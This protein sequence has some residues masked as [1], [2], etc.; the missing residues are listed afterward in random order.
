MAPDDPAEKDLS[1]RF[2][3]WQRSLDRLDELLLRQKLQDRRLKLESGMQ[4]VTD[5]EPL[6]RLLRD[7]EGAFERMESGQYGL[8]QVCLEPI[9][10]DRLLSDPLAN[11]CLEHL[12][13]NQR[14]ALDEDLKL[15]WRIQSQ[16]LPER[17]IRWNGWEVCYHYEP[18]GSVPGDYCDLMRMESGELYFLLGDVSGKG[19]AAS[20]LMSHLH[21]MFHSLIAAGLPFPE[22]VGHA[23][24]LL[25]ESTT[26][27]SFATLT[28]GRA[29]SSGEVQIC[30]AGHCPLVWA[31]RTEITNLNATGIPLGIL[32]DSSY[33]MTMVQLEPGESLVLYTDG[34]T[35]ALD[36][37]GQ[38]YGIDRVVRL[39]AAMRKLSAAAAIDAYLDDLTAFLA[40]SSKHDDLTIMVVKRSEVL[41]QRSAR[42]TSV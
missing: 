22:L 5:R 32:R 18:A 15:A 29:S 14:R 4:L 26:S 30:N 25:C 17:E 6:L 34:L 13:P 27:N 19:I 9:E 10:R 28:L 33:T 35:E 12:T 20:M 8:C 40:G 11:T 31:R 39:M 36:S 7:V 41:D 42:E 2:T 37:S 24:R 1:E 23:N 38:E 21:A 3:F 16:L